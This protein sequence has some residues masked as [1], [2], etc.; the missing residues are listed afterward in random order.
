MPLEYSARRRKLASLSASATRAFARL[1]SSFTRKK[2]RRP[3]VATMMKTMCASAIVSLRHPACASLVA[4]A[5]NETSG[6]DCW[7][8]NRLSDHVLDRRHG[9]IVSFQRL[10]QL[11]GEQE[12]A[13]HVAADIVVLERAKILPSR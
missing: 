1:L 5:P 11:L 12:A 7:R 6:T 2:P 10:G 4:T 8:D 9:A 13:G 3:I